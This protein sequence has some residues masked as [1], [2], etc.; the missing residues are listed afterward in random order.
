MRSSVATGRP[1]RLVVLT[2]TAWPA[3]WLSGDVDPTA[4]R[5]FTRRNPAQVVTVA[6]LGVSN[7]DV[8]QRVRLIRGLNRVA[9]VVVAPQQCD[10]E[11]LNWI[12]S[13]GPVLLIL[14]PT[15]S[16]NRGA[17]KKARAAVA[18]LRSPTTRIGLVNAPLCIDNGMAWHPDVALAPPPAPPKPLICEACA[19]KGACPGPGHTHLAPRP[20]PTPL[21]NQFD[22]IAGKAPRGQPA[23]QID[24]GS[25]PQPHRALIAPRDRAV[26]TAAL[27]HGQLYVD[28]SNQARV[29]DFATQLRP[30]QRS[31]GIWSLAAQQPFAR[32]E[33]QLLDI[34]RS[35]RGFVVDVGAGPIRYV[36]A[37]AEAI[38]AGHL[39]YLA[40]EPDEAA[41]RRSQQALPEGQFVRGIA[42]SLPVQTGCANAIILLR[43]FNHLRDVGQ[44]MR[45]V[46]RA[47]APGARLLVVDNV[48]FGLVRSTEQLQLAHAI[49]TEVTPFEH[50]RN[51]SGR[52]AWTLI[53]RH[54]GPRAQLRQL[55]DVGPGTSNQWL[56]DIVLN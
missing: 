54:L 27:R 41:V 44:A 40:V 6:R 16:T 43:S 17:W 24:V 14:A 46:T 1:Q 32:E 26:L 12:S 2:W 11:L 28:A 49:S 31:G 37:M 9:G 35:L 15:A 36:Q 34:L 55:Q 21:S 45:E 10:D 50:Y 33:A 47:S 20:P 4:L 8:E 56:L 42:E 39:R 23:L 5:L 48:A 3:A 52:R 25:G 13:L 53:K 38:R 29:D 19:N 18:C 51:A 7:Q 30:L 22:V